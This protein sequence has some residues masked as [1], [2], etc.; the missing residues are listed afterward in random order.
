M[1]RIAP[2]YK[3]CKETMK[4]G[5]DSET[6]ARLAIGSLLHAGSNFKKEKQFALSPYFC[7]HCRQ[8][9]I[10]HDQDVLKTK[11]PVQTPTKSKHAFGNKES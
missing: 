2:K 9:H 5:F 1:K 6:K 10:G 8:W 4:R 3:L 7:E 11:F